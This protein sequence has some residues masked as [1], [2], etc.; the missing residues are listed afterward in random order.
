MAGVTGARDAEGGLP[1]GELARSQYGALAS[2]RWSMF[3][4]G[5][6]T[7]K[8]ALE[9]GARSLTY[10]LYLAMGLGLGAAMGGGAYAIASTGKW[11]I[12][13]AIFWG[14]FIM[15]QVVPVSLASFQEQFDMDGL[16]RFP[17]GFGTYYLLHLIFGLIDLSTILGAFCCAGAWVGITLVRPDLSAGAALALLI[18]A[19]FN[20]LLVRAIF[21]WIDRWLAQRRTREIVALLFFVFTISIQLVNPAF[22]TRKYVRISAKSQA[23]GLQ[24]LKTANAVQRWLPPGLAAFEVQ[25]AVEKRTVSG[26]EAL[27]ILGVYALAAGGFLGMRL[28]AEYRGENLNDAPARKKTDRHSGRWLIDGSGPIAAVMEKELRTLGR[29]LPLLFG[30]A[31]PLI[32][33]FLI[34]GL[35]SGGA[36]GR[37]SSM[38]LLICMAYA[39]VGFTQLFYN[40]LGAEGPAVQLLF[41]SPTPI[42]TV[43]LAKNV[44]HGLL[45]LVDAV[46]V[47]VVASLRLGLPSAIA[48]T[49]TA[50]WVLFALA[51]HLTAG[52]ALSITMP[53]RINLGRMSRQRGSQANALV[54]MLIQMAVLGVGTGIFALCTLFDKLWVAVP[55]LLAMAGGASFA[56]L[57][58]LANVDAMANRRREALIGTLVRTE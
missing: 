38:A 58:V 24:W 1:F 22:H 2:M 52:N 43:M 39:M 12:L 48:I 53:Y 51:L 29:G 4:H 28:R 44:F 54:S 7:G 30:L 16:L 6:R 35:F 31:A 21:A 19:A 25:G 33:V 3:R 5:L 13:P 17:V 56:W 14:I 10:L 57:R 41:L 32:T 8:G 20:I 26:M 47:C 55:V 46:L 9:L 15:W 50:A 49:A 40:N 34:S 23:E 37:P 36:R 42:R 45:F 11:E 27:G 18:F